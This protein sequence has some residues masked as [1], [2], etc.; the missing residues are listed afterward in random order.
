MQ[1]GVNFDRKYPKLKELTLKISKR[2][3][4]SDILRNIGNLEKIS[5]EIDSY[6]KNFR[7]ENMQSFVLS[8][9]NPSNKVQYVHIDFEDHS[10]YLFANMINWIECASLVLDF[11][12]IYFYCD[13]DENRAVSHKFWELDVLRLVNVLDRRLILCFALEWN[14]MMRKKSSLKNWKTRIA[15]KYWK[16]VSVIAL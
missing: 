12:N 1:F 16:C 5:I 15:L 3:H 14:P 4:F 9:L 2:R 13:E 7:C 10:G 6:H 8:L 11:S